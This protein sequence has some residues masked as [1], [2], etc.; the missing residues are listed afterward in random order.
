MGASANGPMPC[1]KDTAVE[2]EMA[3]VFQN[4]VQFCPYVRAGRDVVAYYKPVGREGRRK[5]GVRGLGLIL[6][7][8]SRNGEN[9]YHA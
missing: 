7:W 9:R 5:A 3:D 4:R 6:R 8:I 1:A 2:R